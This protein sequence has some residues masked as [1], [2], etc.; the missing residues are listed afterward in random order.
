MPEFR[1]GCRQWG[2]HNFPLTRSQLTNIADG[3]VT[4]GKISG[5]LTVAVGGT[6]ATTLTGYMKGNGTSA[7]TAVTAIPASDVT[8]VPRLTTDNVF[9]G[10]QTINTGTASTKGVVVKGATSQT[11][12]LQEWQT[13]IGTMVVSVGPAGNINII[14]KDLYLH[15]DTNHGIGWYGSGKPFA[16]INVDGPV[17][18]GFSGGGL[19]TINGGQ[20]T[21]LSW[22]NNSKVGINKTPGGDT[23]DVNGNSPDQ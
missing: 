13:S 3:S 5:P 4:S 11:A 18:Y 19:G 10:N 14:D 1:W 15:G 17:L 21:A 6:G 23:L 9:T 7:V 22:D 20:K 12:N 2:R 16:S 8:G